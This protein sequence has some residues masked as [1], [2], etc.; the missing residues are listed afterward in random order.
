LRFLAWQPARWAK[1]LFPQL[2]QM[3][4]QTRPQSLAATLP[5][6]ASRFRV[7]IS[8]K[9][10]DFPHAE[11]VHD[12]LTQSEIPTFF[13]QRSLPQLGKSDYRR[14][15]DQCLDQAEHLVVVTSSA[16]HVMSSWV[17]AEWGFFINEKRS[18]RKQGNVVTLTVGDFDPGELPPALRYYEVIPLDAVGL[19]KLPRYLQ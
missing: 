19:E 10:E 16:S 6:S 2:E 11:R 15:I 4:E 9:S 3:A 7:F 17:E 5:R 13:S 12:F 1:N 18:S 8:C 14:A